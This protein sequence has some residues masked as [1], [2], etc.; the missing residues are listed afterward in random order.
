MVT[1]RTSAKDKSTDI[2]IQTEHV[3]FYYGENQAL[4][5]VTM[6]IPAADQCP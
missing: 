3:N 5:D 4:F 2:A 6:G 1:T